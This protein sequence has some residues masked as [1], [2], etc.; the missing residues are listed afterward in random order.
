MLFLVKEVVELM[1]VNNSTLRHCDKE[2]LLRDVKNKWCMDILRL[3]FSY[4]LSLAFTPNI[5]IN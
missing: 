3:A 5:P 4:I 1:I 2:E